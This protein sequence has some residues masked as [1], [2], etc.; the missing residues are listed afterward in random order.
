MSPLLLCALLISD[1]VT[2]GDAA[3]SFF[4]RVLPRR[5]RRLCKARIRSIKP[6]PYGGLSIKFM[7]RIR[8][9]Y[10]SLRSSNISRWESKGSAP[11]KPTSANPSSNALVRMISFDKMVRLRF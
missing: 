7:I 4:G 8:K 11:V 6:S 5:E 9:L 3:S 1:P 2:Y 10:S